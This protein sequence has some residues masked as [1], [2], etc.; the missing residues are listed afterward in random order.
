MV[1]L[2]GFRCWSLIALPQKTRTFLR[3]LALVPAEL[4]GPLAGPGDQRR[5]VASPAGHRPLASIHLTGARGADS[6]ACSQAV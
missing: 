3:R 5:M 1:V 2:A 4:G 6:I